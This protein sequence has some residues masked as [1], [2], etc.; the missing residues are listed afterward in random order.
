MCLLLDA[1][2]PKLMF[3]TKKTE[4]TIEDK[5]IA[6]EF[7]YH[8]FFHD[9]TRRLLLL[10]KLK[11]KRR[12]N[13]C[14]SSNKLEEKHWYQTTSSDAIFSASM[15]VIFIIHV[16]CSFRFGLHSLL[17]FLCLFFFSFSIKF[18]CCFDVFANWKTR[19]I[20]SK[21]CN[22]HP[23]CTNSKQNVQQTKVWK[24]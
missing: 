3:Q 23:L 2:E 14:K 6:D 13:H 17:C 16:Q 1:F 12:F 4:R 20:D 10:R 5:P 18:C 7:Q 24:I 19:Q 21:P 15:N 22:V 11:K 8:F 9:T